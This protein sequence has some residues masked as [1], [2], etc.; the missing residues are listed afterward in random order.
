[1]PKISSHWSHRLRT[2]QKPPDG[3]YGF[4]A[5]SL[6]YKLIEHLKAYYNGDWKRLS[7]IIQTRSTTAEARKPILQQIHHPERMNGML[8]LPIDEPQSIPSNSTSSA[9][10]SHTGLASG[11]SSAATIAATQF[12][13]G[14]SAN[15]DAP[16][17]RLAAQG[18]TLRLLAKRRVDAVIESTEA[19]RPAKKARQARSCRKCGRASPRT[20]G[21]NGCSG[22]KEVKLCKNACRDCGEKGC[23]GRNPKSPNIVCRE[24]RW[25]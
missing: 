15:A 25:D 14:P 22:A 8:E 4:C 24:A 18:E 9:T 13:A 5:T 23:R 17:T 11:T 6:F 10:I 7:N 2:R 1:M 16:S 12:A 21:A 3:S 20:D 19:T